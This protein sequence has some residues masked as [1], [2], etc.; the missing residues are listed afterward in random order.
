MTLS[1][2]L[3][4]AEKRAC[5]ALTAVSKIPT[6]GKKTFLRDMNLRAKAFNRPG[7]QAAR[8]RRERG[9]CAEKIKTPCGRSTRQH[10]LRHRN[11]FSFGI[12]E[13]IP[14]KEKTIA[15]ND[16]SSNDDKSD[17]SAKRKSR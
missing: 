5:A 12:T 4:T 1:I 8:T 3:V 7:S 2:D 14:L 13:S 16:S 15:S 10:S 9:L 17:A 11:L 6:S